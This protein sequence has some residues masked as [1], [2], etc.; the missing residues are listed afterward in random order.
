MQPKRLLVLTGVQNDFFRLPFG[1]TRMTPILPKIADYVQNWDGDIIVVKETRL[2]KQL[3]ELGHGTVPGIKPWNEMREHVNI[4]YAE[5]CIKWTDGWE[6]V[7]ELMPVL[8]EKNEKSCRFRTVE[9]YGQTWHDWGNNIATYDQ[10]TVAGTKLEDQIVSTVYAIRAFR[11]DVS[12]KIP[13]SLCAGDS[14]QIFRTVCSILENAA[15]L[16]WSLE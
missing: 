10:I 4:G 3:I 11:P 15:S 7:P 6:I 5:H 9:A 1:N 2:T 12:I 14:D 13:L 8:K 16:T